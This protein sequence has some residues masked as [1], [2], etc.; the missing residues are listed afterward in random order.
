MTDLLDFDIEVLRAASR[1]IIFFRIRH[2]SLSSLS[3][4]LFHASDSFSRLLSLSRARFSPFLLFFFSS[5]FFSFFAKDARFFFLCFF[6]LK[7]S[8]VYKKNRSLL[9]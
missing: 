3:L 8:L 4:S 1:F 9:E 6:L 2:V 7:L 5:L